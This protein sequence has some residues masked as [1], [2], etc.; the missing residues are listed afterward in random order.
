M[1]EFFSTRAHDAPVIVDFHAEATSEKIAM[2]W[3]LDGRAACVVGTHTH[4]Q[5]ADETSPAERHRVH[6][7]HGHVGADQFRDRHGQSERSSR[8]FSRRCRRST[9]WREGDLE[10]QGVMI[11]IDARTK[12]CVDIKRIREK[13]V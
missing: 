8:G 11:T 12:Q 6:H 4:V 9:R 2:G 13:I 7:G 5:T 10:V 3:F 1:E